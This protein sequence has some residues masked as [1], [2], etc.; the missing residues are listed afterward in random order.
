VEFGA[1]SGSMSTA[2]AQVRTMRIIALGYS[3]T[4]CYGLPPMNACPVRV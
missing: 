2:S 4:A 1:L 3:L